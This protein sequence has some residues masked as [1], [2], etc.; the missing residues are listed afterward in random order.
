V[1]EAAATSS[2]QLGRFAPG[3][4]VTVREGPVEADGYRWWRVESG[5]GLSGWAADGDGEDDWLT[6]DIG[7]PRPVNRPLRVGDR[8]TVTTKDGKHLALRYQAAGTLIR[9]VPAGTLFT[10]KEGPVDAEGF[11]WWLLADDEGMEGWAAES[12][13]ETRWLTP[14]E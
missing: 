13:G 10:V 7:E 14:L 11:R 8:L 4:L 3:T 1:R 2:K 6:G 9:R 12:D 5:Q